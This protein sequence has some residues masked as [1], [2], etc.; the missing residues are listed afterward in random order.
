MKENGICTDTLFRF[1]KILCK[2]VRSWYTYTLFEFDFKWF[3][4]NHYF[5]RIHSQPKIH[6]THKPLRFLFRMKVN[7][8]IKT[9]RMAC[10]EKKSGHWLA[11]NSQVFPQLTFSHSLITA[12]VFFKKHISESALIFRYVVK[13][14]FPGYALSTFTY[15]SR[16]QDG[17]L[18]FLM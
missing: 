10:D 13:R 14:V 11:K 4:Q 2:L 7:M 16:T 15:Q 1:W 5:H 3:N 6:Y 8:E 17:I 9:T 12:T 18:P